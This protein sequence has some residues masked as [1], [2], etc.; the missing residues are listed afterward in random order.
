MMRLIPL[1][2][3]FLLFAHDG[4][5]AIPTKSPKVTPPRPITPLEERVIEIDG[6]PASVAMD[7]D[8]MY[9]SVIGKEMNLTKDDEDGAI[10]VLKPGETSPVKLTRD[11]EFSAPK[12]IAVDKD[13]I[14]VT[15]I[16]ALYV[17]DKEEGKMQSYASF[18]SDG[19]L[20][21]INDLVLLGDGRIIVSCTDNNKIYICD[22][23]T[24]SYSE[25]VTKLPLNHPTGLAWDAE[26]KLLYIVESASI[27]E[28]NK[29][30]PCG[31]L[32]TINIST[33]ATSVISTNF[34][35]MKGL[36]NGIALK[37]GE[38]YFCDW[39]KNKLPEAI[40]KLNLKSNKVSKLAR[41]SMTGVSDF[42]IRGNQYIAPSM[43]DRKIYIA[44]LPKEKR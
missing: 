29:E 9:I 6:R 41:A 16:D 13:F 42:I 30:V 18:A 23:R 11:G 38:V 12:G 1:F 5:C 31:R 20:S 17:L 27:K 25:I 40:R 36:F 33:G 37:D 2:G 39:S 21:Y 19:P 14:Y 28:G 22:P 43:E 7:G 3:I 10:Y 44:N 4:F 34:D 32:L 15:D 35:Q 8:T 24:K 26:N